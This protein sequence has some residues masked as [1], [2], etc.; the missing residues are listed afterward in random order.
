MIQRKKNFISS[1]VVG[2]V[3]AA[4]GGLGGFTIGVRIGSSGSVSVTLPMGVLSGF[5]SGFLVSMWYLKFMAN[6]GWQ[7]REV[8]GLLF[9]ALAG[10]S[11]AIITTM[12]DSLFFVI[13][14]PGEYHMINDILGLGLWTVSGVIVGAVIGSIFS[15]ILGT[16]FAPELGKKK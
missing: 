6:R 15:F 10:A 16:F 11:C 12:A 4:I 8:F 1:L 13:S 14:S 7:R 2:V 5:L 9:G 3:G